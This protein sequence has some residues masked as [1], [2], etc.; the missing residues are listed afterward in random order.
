MHMHMHKYIC[1]QT[2]HNIVTCTY[3]GEVQCLG[4]FART[5]ADGHTP[6]TWTQQ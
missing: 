1:K 6:E 5:D 3:Q 2:I 4:D